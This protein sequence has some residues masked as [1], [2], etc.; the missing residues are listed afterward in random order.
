MLTVGGGCSVLWGNGD[1]GSQIN[2][3]YGLCPSTGCTILISAGTYAYTTNVLLTTSGKWVAVVGNPGSVVNLI[4]SGSGN[5]FTLDYV[6]AGGGGWKTGHGLRNFNLYN[7]TTTQIVGG[8]NKAIEITAWSITSNVVTFTINSNAAGANPL[9][10]GNVV[11]LNGFQFNASSSSGQ[12]LFNNQQVTVISTGLSSTQFEANFTHANT[13]LT[14][15]G[16]A[17]TTT[18]TNVG[19]S[20]GPNNSGSLSGTYTNVQVSGFFKGIQFNNP[21][22]GTISWGEVFDQVSIVG[23]TFGYW[24]PDSLSFL[25]NLHVRSGL[26]AWNA[27]GIYMGYGALIDFY[28]DGPS[29]DSNTITGFDAPFGGSYFISTSHLENNGLDGNSSAHYINS[30]PGTSIELRSSELLKDGVAT[31]D[32]LM[33]VNGGSSAFYVQN[34]HLFAGGVITQFFKIESGAA[35]TI[36]CDIGSGSASTKIWNFDSTTSG[37][38]NQ[39]FPTLNRT[40]YQKGSGAG[41]YTTTSLTPAVVDGTNL[42]LTIV[43]PHGYTLLIQVSGNLGNNTGFPANGATAN[44][45]DTSTATI[46]QSITSSVVGAGDANPFSLLGAIVGDGA[47]HVIQLQFLTG[48]AGDPAVIY[49]SGGLFP[50]MLFHL[51][52]ST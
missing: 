43:I 27:L 13:S 21:T 26:I 47:S 7:K 18:E 51:I 19:V 5:A 31:V 29:L 50:V 32:W 42:S 8:P 23:N 41:N 25:E 22:G 40:I 2:T 36:S 24:F 9:I 49:N 48:N 46:L 3:A 39:I 10:A 20:I 52:P 37:T 38:V 17:Y 11:T 44:L 1:I 14:E 15:Y 33:R 6:P 35:G 34:C 30:G 28:I 4:F 45:T 12:A 16:F